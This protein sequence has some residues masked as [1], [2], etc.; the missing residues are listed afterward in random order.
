MRRFTLLYKNPRT[1]RFALVKTLKDERGGFVHPN[2][3]NTLGWLALHDQSALRNHWQVQGF[4]DSMDQERVAVEAAE[5]AHHSDLV[6]SELA[7]RLK[8]ILPKI[9]GRG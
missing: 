5:D 4:L 7:P 8:F 1:G 6:R 2:L 9:I 3:Y